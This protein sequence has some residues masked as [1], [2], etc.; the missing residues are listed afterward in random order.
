MNAERGFT[1]RWRVSRRLLKAAPV[2]AAVLVLG[3]SAGAS[4]APQV[5]SSVGKAG[6]MPAISDTGVKAQS[7]AAWLRGTK[8][9]LAIPADAENVRRIS[10]LPL[11]TD[12]F[13]IV[14]PGQVADVAVHK[15]TAYVMS[16]T[17]PFDFTANRCFRGGF[18]T[19]DISNPEAPRQL[20][21]NK[22][23][24]KNYHGEGAHAITFPD[25]RDVL[26]VNN[27]TCFSAP[28]PAP[29]QGGGFDLWDVSNPANPQPLVR[30][31]GDYGPIGNLVCCTR[32][33]PGANAAIAHSYHSVFM[34]RD[35][36]KVYLVGVDNAEQTRTDVDI[37]DI[38][39]PTAPVAVGEFDLDD[40][41]DLFEP[42]EATFQN[43]P[44][45][46]TG[47]PLDTNLHD[48][49]VK[50]IDGVQTMLASY[51]DGGYVLLNVENPAAPEYIGDSTFKTTDPLTGMTPANGNAH[52]AEFSFDNKFILAA[53]EVLTQYRADTALDPGGPKEFGGFGWGDPTEGPI[54]SPTDEFIGPTLFV[55]DGCTAA[56]IPVNTNPPKIAVIERGT[57][58]FQIKVENADARGYDR[59][60]VFNSNSASNGCEA[61]L[62]MLFSG[63][64]GDAVSV[65]VSRQVG[66]RLIDAYDPATYTCTPGGATTPSPAPGAAGRPGLNLAM[67]AIFHGWGYAHLYR[68][69]SGRLTEVGNGY[70]IPETL[71]E[72]YALGFGDLSIHE[73]A[74]DPNTNLAYSAYYAG[75]LRVVSYGDNGIQ[76]VG[77]YIEDHG[78]NFWGVE[79]FTTDEQQPRRL[80]AASDRDFGLYIFEYTG[81]GAVVLP[82]KPQPAA[83]AAPAAAPTK[84]VAKPQIVSL[85][86]ANRSLRKLRRGTLAVRL[87][88]NEASRVQVTLQ[89]RLTSKSGKRGS[90]Q[91]LARTTLSNVAANQTRTITLRISSSLRKRLRSE[92][93]VPAR[94]SFRVTDVAG[95]V[96]TRN[97][98]LTF[99]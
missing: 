7:G 96:T 12:E 57:C 23:L 32:N 77:R 10:R 76:E 15:N 90:L 14:A 46:N 49:V 2:L 13:G 5:S 21:F 95:N 28:T 56:N 1:W 45:P 79:Q 66:M 44:D 75:G 65:F 31:A 18:W 80:I 29:A 71:D 11:S 52:Q 61:L 94:L 19:V 81:P 20:S 86:Q 53:D 33:A 58:G 99:R 42:G 60:V 25:G 22:A 43:V 69:G 59:V 87:R 39:D 73:W 74:T 89:G 54:F 30:A 37:F 92:K 97:V 26:A 24:D 16:W 51:W 36:A 84:D 34:W 78:N 41:F 4:A 9:A 40:E 47:N 35:G 85:R 17:Q 98:S 93:R 50:D 82:P 63:Y 67:D 88:L 27:E 83:P 8:A 6:T 72:N 3:A 38:T 91:R 62:G 64:T 68:T 70:A 48:M 55:G